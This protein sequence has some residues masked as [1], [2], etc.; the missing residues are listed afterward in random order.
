[1]A[2]QTNIQQQPMAELTIKSESQTNE[3]RQMSIQELIDSMK[4]MA[5]DVGQISELT[6]EE[7]N[8]VTEF[9][10]SLLK[11]MQPLC[12]E[13]NVSVS[14]LPEDAGI[15]ASAHIDPT[16]H[17]ALIFE[18]GH[19][20]LKNLSEENNRDLLISVVQDIIPKFKQLTGA[21]KR[22]IENRIKFLST[23]TK[24]MQKISGALAA[25]ASGT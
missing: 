16:G 17:L 1:M 7:K 5:D 15:L 6:S 9:F 8:L 3:R 22:K 19:L 2:Q 20:E 14:A 11:L 18:D 25:D 21:Q 10:K 13:I 12:T 23:V 4:S 24:E